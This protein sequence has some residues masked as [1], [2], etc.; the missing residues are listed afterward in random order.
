MID[1][2]EAG[3]ARSRKFTEEWLDKEVAKKRLTSD[4]KHATLHDITYSLKLEDL[5]P[6][7][8]IIEAAVEDFNVKKPLFET[9]D[10]V[11]APNV[12]LASNTSSISITKLAAVTKRPQQVIGMHFFNPVPVMKLVEI[13]QGLQTSPETSALASAYACTFVCR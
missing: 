5:Q 12:V 8:Y 6:A 3:I 10:K 11:T 9:L 7:E 4:E 2:N 13:I 1:S